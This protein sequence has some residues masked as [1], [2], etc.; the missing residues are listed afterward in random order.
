[1]KSRNIFLIVFVIIAIILSI[2][3]FSFKEMAIE[4]KYGEF[5]ELYG[6]IDKSKNYIVVINKTNYGFIEKLGNDIFVNVDNCYKFILEYSNNQIEVYEFN[7]RE[8]LNTLTFNDIS[9]IKKRS[10]TRLIFNSN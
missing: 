1:M 4:D 8:T 7:S 10:D 6:K 3:F 9:T 5:Y 2:L